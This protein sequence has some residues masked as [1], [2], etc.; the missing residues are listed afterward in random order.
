MIGRCGRGRGLSR[1]KPAPGRPRSQPRAG[2]AEPRAP[3]LSSLPGRTASGPATLSVQREPPP[4]PTSLP[5]AVQPG[6][7]AAM[8]LIQNMCTIAEYPAPG[9]TA[10][11]CCLGAAGRR[12]VKIAVVGASGVGKT[13]E[14]ERG[15]CSV[16]GRDVGDPRPDPSGERWALQRDPPPLLVPASMLGPRWPRRFS[17]QS[18]N[19]GALTLW[20]RWGR[21]VLELCGVGKTSARWKEGLGVAP[22]GLKVGKGRREGAREGGTHKTLPSARAVIHRAS[23]TSSCPAEGSRSG[24]LGISLG[25]GG[26]LRLS[27]EELFSWWGRGGEPSD[28]VG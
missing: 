21:T 6:P 14:S 22:A 13:G 16:E 23:S 4:V 28:S 11:D 17:G 24:R 20:P 5:R 10:A 27:L 9:S 25:G 8:R 7:A 2:P 18:K 12:L 19:F 15:S 3:P 1:R 26:G